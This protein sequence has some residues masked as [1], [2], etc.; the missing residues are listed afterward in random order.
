MFLIAAVVASLVAVEAVDPPGDVPD[1]IKGSIVLIILSRSILILPLI[2][3]FSNIYISQF[4]IMLRKLR[5]IPENVHFTAISEP[6][7]F[8]TP[9]APLFQ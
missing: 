6:V 5:S 9:L 3:F 7:V 2:I 4:P 8:L 1:N